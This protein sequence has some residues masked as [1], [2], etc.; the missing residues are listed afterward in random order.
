MA[1]NKTSLSAGEII[2]KMLLADQEV[3][4]RTKKVFPVVTDSAE[5]PYI[6][7]RRAQ[8]DHNPVKGR[9]GADTVAME[10]ICYAKGYTE[11]V[12]LAEAV[13]EVLDGQQGEIPGL[14]MRGSY[15]ADSEESWSDD[16]YEQRLVFNIKL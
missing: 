7:Y 5:L 4:K 12:E 3:A 8:L 15:L 6:L 9:M 2:R 10:I 11:S 1:V 14:V 16:A 13:R